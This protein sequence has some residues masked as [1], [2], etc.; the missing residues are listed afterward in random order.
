MKTKTYDEVIGNAEMQVSDTQSWYSRLRYRLIAHWR[1]MRSPSGVFIGIRDVD[2]GFDISLTQYG[3]FEV[4]AQ[5]LHKVFD[6]YYMMKGNQ[7]T[8][9][10]ILEKERSA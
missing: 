9:S 3:K 2:D 6:D 10:K 1:F 7:N 8:I 5:V 4:D